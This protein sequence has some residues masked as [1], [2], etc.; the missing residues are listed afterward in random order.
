MISD[1]PDAQPAERDRAKRPVGLAR[2]QWSDGAPHQAQRSGNGR[3][4][5]AVRRSVFAAPS[6]AELRAQ[7][8]GSHS[9]E[10]LDR[11]SLRVVELPRSAAFF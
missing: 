3:R 11:S 5:C 2:L 7:W 10:R 1:P 6:I 4:S 9:A 8:S